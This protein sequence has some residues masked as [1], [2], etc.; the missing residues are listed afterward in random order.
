MKTIRRIAVT[1]LLATTAFS[2]AIASPASARVR[3]HVSEQARAAH[4]QAYPGGVAPLYAPARNRPNSVYSGS[5]PDA[6]IR[7]EESKDCHAC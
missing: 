5:D 3:S 1:V 2:A 6:Y 4:A 7:I